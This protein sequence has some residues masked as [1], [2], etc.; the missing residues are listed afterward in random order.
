[1]TPAIPYSAISTDSRQEAR[2]VGA[3][4]RL[5][6]DDGHTESWIY[7]DVDRAAT[8]GL[9]VKGQFW[10]RPNDTLGLAGVFDGL[11]RVHQEFF[12]AGGVGILAGDGRLN[13][14]WEKTLETYYDIQVWK[15]LHAALDYQFITDPAFNRDRGPVSVFGARVHWEL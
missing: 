8:A 3:F 5:G 6:W 1:M 13:Y 9:S 7:T 4:A 12:E 14:G 10:S 11:S 2:N 15:S